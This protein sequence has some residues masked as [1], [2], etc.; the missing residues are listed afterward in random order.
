[1]YVFIC[2]FNLILT[3]FFAS[4]TQ[5]FPVTLPARALDLLPFLFT[6]TIPLPLS[7]SFCFVT[8]AVVEATM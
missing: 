3:L 2:L 8:Q 6:L 4:R 1:M 5:V 7:L